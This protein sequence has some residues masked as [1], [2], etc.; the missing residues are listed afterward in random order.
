MIRGMSQRFRVVAFVCTLA[1]AAAL[2][3]AWAVQSGQPGAVTPLARWER[4]IDAWEAGD[5]PAALTELRTLMRSPAAAEFADRAAQL[6]GEPYA[7]TYLADD[8]RNPRVSAD[9]QFATYETGSPAV[10]RLV[11]VAAPD[12]PLAD[13]PTTTVAF[14]RSGRRLAWL[15]QP[16]GAPASAADIVVRD[17]ASGAE[18]VWLRAGLQKSGLDWSG[19]DRRVVFVGAE[20]GNTTS[21]DVYAVGAD[22]TAASLTPGTT[23]HKGNVQIGTNGTLVYTDAPNSPFAGRG[24]RGAGGGGG[25]GR[26]G[27]RGGGAAPTSYVVTSS[28]ARP[29]NGTAVTLSA[30]GSAVAWIQRDQNSATVMMAPTSGGAATELRTVTSPHRLGNSID[31]SP[32]GQRAAYEMMTHTDWEIWVTD[33][34]GT[35]QRVT[36]DIQHDMVPRFLSPT[37]LFSVK[38]E[39]RH[40]RSHLYDLTTGT[41]VRI[42]GNNLIRTI[43]PEYIW[44]PSASGRVLAVQADRDGDTISPERSVTIVDLG[45]KV[46]AADVAARIDRQLA[47]ENDLRARMTK[48]YAP[49]RELAERVVAKARVNRVYEHEAVMAT[50]DSKHITMPGNAKAIDYLEKAYRS[51]GYEPEL[52][53]FEAAGRGG[54]AP[55][56]TANVIATLRGTED[57]HLVYVVSSHF[58][59]VAAGPGAD[60]DTSGTAALLEAARILKDTPLPVTIKFASF[61]GEEAGLLGSREFVRQASAAKMQVVGALNNDMIGW[62]GEGARMDNTIRYSNV[63]I[64]DLQHGAAFLFTRLITYDAKYYRSTD[65]AA[66]YEAWGDIVGGIGSYPV[67]ANPNYHQPTDFLETM[68]FHQIMETAKVTAAT[69]VYLA[70]SPS[71]LKD[72]KAQRTGSGVEVTW[73]PSPESGIKSYLVAFGT[74]PDPWRNKT[75]TVAGPRATLPGLPPGTHV[76]VKAVNGRGLEGWDWARVVIQ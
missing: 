10:T 5:Y 60:D 14:D 43:A 34:A 12:K 72:V 59:S 61:T 1:A 69:L 40:R 62:S 26:G 45:R 41:A 39:G 68:N 75:M 2:P 70:S 71:R 73:T 6:T 27:G 51:F 74:S 18:Q 38:G 24:G 37:T 28:G 48:A 44:A 55:I 54:G 8:G 67:L 23:G 20:D 19:D 35:H 7:S 9:G 4:A 11:R 3:A 63:G 47:E 25:G 49:V 17:L 16:N 22:G 13:L 15:R 76:A 46:A 64:K 42:F 58:D 29:I 50:F 36:R 31:I 32:D 21:S 30:D 65:A 53:W 56:K 33:R 66:F 52:Q 57:P